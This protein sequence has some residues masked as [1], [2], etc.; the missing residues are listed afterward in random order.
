METNDER[1]EICNCTLGLSSAVVESIITTNLGTWGRC[2]IVVH[3]SE[4]YIPHFHIE[5]KDKNY[6]CCICLFEP[7]YFNHDRNHYEMGPKELN[8]LDIVLRSKS[9]K[10]KKGNPISPWEIAVDVW[11]NY[12][13]GKGEGFEHDTDYKN[14]SQPNYNLTSG[15]RYTGS[16]APNKRK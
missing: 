16:K 10:D 15:N 14:L 8:D 3:G 12:K 9:Y 11:A 5:P 2:T 1:T 6:E 13:I 7:T 4:G